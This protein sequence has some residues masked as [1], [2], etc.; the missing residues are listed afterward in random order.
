M[1]LVLRRWLAA[2]RQPDKPGKRSV[3][4]EP[5]SGGDIRESQNPQTGHICRRNL[6]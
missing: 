5:Q 1:T 2:Q 6:Q 4:Y 3:D